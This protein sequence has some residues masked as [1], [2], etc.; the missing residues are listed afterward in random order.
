VSHSGVVTSSLIAGGGS[1]EVRDF[2]QP[3]PLHC[4]GITGFMDEC[5]R[6]TRVRAVSVAHVNAAAK[7]ATSAAGTPPGARTHPLAQPA[8]V[9]QRNRHSHPATQTPKIDGAYCACT[10]A[11]GEAWTALSRIR[12]ST[13]RRRLE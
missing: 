7:E 3:D 12:T 2:G 10:D 11:E 6:M 8:S 9:A 1:V 4:H 5:L 13:A